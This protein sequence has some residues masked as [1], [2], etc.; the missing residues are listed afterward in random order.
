[1]SAE[2]N[3]HLPHIGDGVE[4]ALDALDDEPLDED[5]VAAGAAAAA[6]PV[7]ESLDER[8]EAVV[9]ELG[10][11]TRFREGGAIRYAA[12]G[13][14]FAVLDLDRLEVG[15]DQRVATAALRTPDTAP[16]SSGPG[17]IAFTPAAIDRYALD[18]AEAWVRL[19]HRRATG[20]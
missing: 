19:A 3:G 14:V 8:V 7:S 11:V 4:D 18:R 2:G 15:L 12:A 5:E 10:E 20:R 6:D 17:W 9:D 1:V 13:Q 16:T